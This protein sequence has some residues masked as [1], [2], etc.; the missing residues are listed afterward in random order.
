MLAIVVVLSAAN[1]RYLIAQ[2]ACSASPSDPVQ[3][4]LDIFDTSCSC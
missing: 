1:L 4:L 3:E 2:E